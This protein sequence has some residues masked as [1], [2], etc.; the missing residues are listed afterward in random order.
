MDDR[1]D[2]RE[3]PFFCM[4]HNLLYEGYWLLHEDMYTT[5]LPSELNCKINR[6]KGDIMCLV[7]QMLWKIL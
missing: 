7:T 1:E 6:L 4:L 3:S 5:G 2:D